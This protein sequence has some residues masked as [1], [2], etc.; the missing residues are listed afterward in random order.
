[1]TRMIQRDHSVSLQP[2]NVAASPQEHRE[3]STTLPEVVRF[4]TDLG[5]DPVDREEHALNNTV[6]Y[7]LY[8]LNSRLKVYV[9]LE[10]DGSI[11]QIYG[12]PYS[13]SL[14]Y[15]N[16]Q[17]KLHLLEMLNSFNAKLR[18]GRWSIDN[19]GD[20]RVHFSLFLEDS[21]LTRRQL[22]R[23]NFL[24]S[25]LMI[26]QGQLLQ[27]QARMPSPLEHRLLGLS[28]A[29]LKAV[30][31]H[32]DALNDIIVA[33]RASKDMARCLYEVAGKEFIAEDDHDDDAEATADGTPSV[34]EPPSTALH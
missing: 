5:Y 8:T 20:S 4:I 15:I 1:M 18:Y 16:P 21:A 14:E 3:V 30:I 29:V 26:H 32:P 25:D 31:D 34:D 6:C 13:H 2:A 27:M 23:I 33:T 10:N 12:Y 17:A 22:A 11:V 7:Y 9:T 28:A 24:L 19:D